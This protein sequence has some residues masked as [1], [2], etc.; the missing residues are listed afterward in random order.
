MTEREEKVWAAR[1]RL[2]GLVNEYILR[3]AARTGMSPQALVNLALIYAM[4][5][6]NGWLPELPYPELAEVSK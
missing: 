1:P 3:L 5:H 6:Q 2:Y 4:Q